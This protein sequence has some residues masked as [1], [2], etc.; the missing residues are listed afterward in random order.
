QVDDNENMEIQRRWL[1]KLFNRG[2]DQTGDIEELQKNNNYSRQDLNDSISLD[3]KQLDQ[4]KTSVRQSKLYAPIDGTVSI[5]K[6]NLEGSTSVRDEVVMQVKD[7]TE[8][9]FSSKIM[10]YKDIIQDG[11]Q[12]EMKVVSGPSK[13]TYLV[14]PYLKSY[15]TDQMFFSIVEG[16]EG[17]IFDAGD[18]GTVTV[19]LGERLDVLTLP[20]EAVHGA[21]EKWYVYVLNDEG[22]RDV[23]W[24]EVGLSGDGVIEIVSGLEE[25]EKVILK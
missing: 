20:V 22:S 19:I 12:L 8:C 7:N 4:I 11:Q 9:F 17:A 6:K 18:T 25:G 23:K 2:F 3:Q 15:W 1:N 16:G 21:D 13:G 24:I 10:T 14:E 5:V